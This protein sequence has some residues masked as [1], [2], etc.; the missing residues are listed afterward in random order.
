MSKMSDA[1]KKIRHVIDLISSGKAHKDILEKVN[2][3]QFKTMERIGREAVDNYYDD[4]SERTMYDPLGS[5]YSAYKIKNKDGDIIIEYD[6]SY[7]NGEH[8]VDNSYIYQY[9]FEQGYHGG[10]NFGGNMKIPVGMPAKPYNG[11]TGSPWNNNFV[12]HKWMDAYQSPISPKEE[13]D[14][15]VEEYYENELEYDVSDA[16][17]EW[18]E[19]NDI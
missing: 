18:R 12:Q 2:N 7:L 19:E 17:D 14:E 6:S 11:T 5:L 16:L 10:A 3:K 1:E 4:Y 9:M 13:I 8:R 15:K